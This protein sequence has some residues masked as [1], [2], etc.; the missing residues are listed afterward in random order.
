MASRAGTLDPL[1]SALRDLVAWLEARQVP[2][3][4]IGGVAVSLLARPR[5]TRDVDAMVLLDDAR[6]E[7]FLN[8]G[9]RFGFHPRMENSLGFAR[10]KRVLLLRHKPSG[11]DVDL[12]FGS[13]SFEKEA[14]ARSR[15]VVVG[16]VALPLPSPEDLIIMK[17]IAPRARDQG[18]IEALLDAQPKLDLRRI[19]R[20]VRELSRAMDKPDVAR[21]LERILTRRRR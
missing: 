17:A 11:V 20:W 16:G 1:L 13:L 3:L 19:R 5:V 2:G 12:V 7:E 21:E 15:R 6:W 4:I 9:T 18:D 14:V 10:K 8:S